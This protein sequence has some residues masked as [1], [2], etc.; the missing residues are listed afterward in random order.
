MVVYPGPNTE[1]G[2]EKVGP[3]LIGS[4]PIEKGINP[5]AVRLKLARTMQI[6]PTFH[7]SQVKQIQESALMP[8]SQ[9]PPPPQIIDG[10]PTFTVHCLVCA[11][12]RGRG[13]Q[14]HVD[15]EGYSPGERSWVPACQILDARLIQELLRRHPDQ[16]SSIAT[17][18]R[19][20]NADPQSSPPSDM[21]GDEEEEDGS[22]WKGDE[23]Y[24]KE[25]EEEMEA[26]EE[27]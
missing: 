19:G 18:G 26:S 10:A 9:P 24:S 12:H 27:F 5:V 13:L 7:A 17:V 6:H 1:S 14:Y 21:S 15:W 8:A 4:F 25:E 16:P 20:A 22:C 3:Q 23:P 2:V 11:R